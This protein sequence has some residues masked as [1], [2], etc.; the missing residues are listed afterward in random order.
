MA[1]SLQINGLPPSLA[2]RGAA[3]WPAIAEWYGLPAQVIE[4]L[5]TSPNEADRRCYRWLREDWERAMKGG[6]VDNVPTRLA[7][8]EDAIGREEATRRRARIEFVARVVK[9]VMRPRHVVIAQDSIIFFVFLGI[10][11]LM[12]YVLGALP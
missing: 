10:V 6:D 5:A 1:T 7:Y 2:D 8:Y 11:A 3:D 4:G 12:L 9:R